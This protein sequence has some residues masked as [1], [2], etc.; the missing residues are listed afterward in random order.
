VGV[1]LADWMEAAMYY[2]LYCACV[3]HIYK[4]EHPHGVE[5]GKQLQLLT[6]PE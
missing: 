6:S 1:D 5:T 2:V 3:L 4:A